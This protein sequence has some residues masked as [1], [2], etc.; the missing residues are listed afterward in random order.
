MDGLDTLKVKYLTA[1]AAAADEAALEDVRLAALGKKGEISALMLGLGKM[2]PDQRKAAGALLNVLRDEIDASLRAKKAA[3]THQQ[4]DVPSLGRGR[5]EAGKPLEH[6]RQPRHRARQHQ[7][8]VLDR[9]AHHLLPLSL[10]SSDSRPV[11][12]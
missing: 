9:L 2:E 8:A 4:H 11:I 12:S 5:M 10:S 6:E 1:V 7:R 3:L